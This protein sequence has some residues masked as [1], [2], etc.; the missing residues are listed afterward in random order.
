MKKEPRVIGIDDAPFDKFDPMQRHVLVVG[1][2]FRGG[3]F[4]DGMLSTHVDKDGEDATLRIVEMIN[5]CKFK[6]QVRAIFLNG[7]AV[8]G[9]NVINP[10]TLSKETGIPVIVVIRDYPDYKKIFSAL[11]KLGMKKKIEMIK[12]IPKPVKMNDIYV[13]NIGISKAETKKLLKICCTHSNI[14]E[15]IRASH[16]IA[17]GIAD[18]E[19]RGRA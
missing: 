11:E 6:P 2:V 15:A 18:G 13:Q 4:M 5:D 19:S 12:K 1:T 7:I 9:F 3:S 17:S 8:A 16:L 14:P 10:I